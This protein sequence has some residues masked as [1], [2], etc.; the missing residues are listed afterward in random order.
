MLD[1]FRDD[2]DPRVPDRKAVE[3]AADKREERREGRVKAVEERRYVR[4]ITVD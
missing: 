3:N 4:V 2:Q 1:H